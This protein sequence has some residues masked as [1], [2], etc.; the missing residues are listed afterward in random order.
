MATFGQGI[1]AQLG[2]I[3]YSPIQRGSAVGAQLAAQGGSMI[4]QGLANLGQEVGKGMQI[5]YKKKEENK[6]MDDGINT[7]QNLNTKSPELFANLIQDPNDRGAWKALIKTAGGP[8]QVMQMATAINAGIDERGGQALAA[9][10]SSQGTTEISP[11]DG[12]T[13]SARARQL[14]RNQFM[15]EQTDAANLANTQAETTLRLSNADK[16]GRPVLP[17]PKEGMRYLPDG[18]QEVIP[19]S[20]LERT[21]QLENDK[22]AREDAAAV[23]ADLAASQALIKERRIE[24][25]KSVETENA[26][27]KNKNNV[28]TTL[29]NAKE[30]LKLLQ[31]A[32]TQLTND[33]G[34]TVMGLAPVRNLTNMAS[35]LF[36]AFNQNAGREL[37][38]AQNLNTTYDK[39]KGMGIIAMIKGFKD[40]SPTGGGIFAGSQSDAEGKWMQDANGVLNTSNSNEQQVK[41][42]NE[43]IERAQRT[44]V[45]PLLGAQAEVDSEMAK[46]NIANKFSVR[47]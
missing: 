23:R 17:P 43:M 27:Q 14:G 15:K 21:I 38:K 20:D 40:N 8:A 3:D 1:N 18:S 12:T 34:G 6:L 46:R 11:E 32:R 30:Y 35:G 9:M 24:Q 29:Y 31:D 28:A 42:I 33:A 47:F 37:S 36:G 26:F 13:Y 19:G 45:D 10:Y 39:L 2:A 22:A 44:L 25:E 5:Y 41:S 7:L 16:A 4:G